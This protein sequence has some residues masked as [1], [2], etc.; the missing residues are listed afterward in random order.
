MQKIGS[1]YYDILSWVASEALE[2]SPGAVVSYFD[3]AAFS[4]P[5]QL[6]Y[7]HRPD[8]EHRLVQVVAAAAMPASL[9]VGRLNAAIPGFDRGEPLII[10]FSFPRRSLVTCP[11]AVARVGNWLMLTYLDVDKA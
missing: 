9:D 10:S 1:F 4:I 3:V 11:R 6:S 7:L 5:L 2:S 8:I